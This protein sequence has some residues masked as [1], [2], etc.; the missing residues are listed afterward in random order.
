MSLQ[1][2]DDYQYAQQNPR[3]ESPPRHLQPERVSGTHGTVSTT[4]NVVSSKSK[5]NACSIM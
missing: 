3:E 4:S 5:K 1:I 2:E